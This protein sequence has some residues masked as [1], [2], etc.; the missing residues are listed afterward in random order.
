MHFRTLF[1]FS[2]FTWKFSSDR[3]SL[4]DP[5]KVEYEESWRDASWDDNDCGS[6]GAQLHL[7]SGLVF[8]Q[9]V[10][11]F[12]RALRHCTTRVCAVMEERD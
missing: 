8:H 6:L 2:I 12:A 7:P 1:C 5:V 3:S 9:D 4:L 10:Y 11:P